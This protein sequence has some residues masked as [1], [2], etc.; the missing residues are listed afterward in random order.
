L[1]RERPTAARSSHRAL[2]V[3]SLVAA[4]VGCAHAMDRNQPRQKIVDLN[5]QALAAYQEED[6]GA[7]MAALTKAL[8]EAK[9]AG[10]GR[11][12]LTAR[13]YVHLGAVY[14]IGYRDLAMA[15]RSFALAKA[16]RP[17][18][19]MTPAI[20]TPELRMVFDEAP[21]GLTRDPP[22]QAAVTSE[23]DLPL[24]FPPRSPLVC[25]TPHVW[26]P[27]KA[28]S[29]RCVVDPGLNAESVRMH[30]RATH[31]ED[32]ETLSMQRS[33]KGWY[34][35]TV[36][37]RVVEPYNMQMY[38]EARDWSGK[39]VAMEGQPDRPLIIRIC[40]DEGS[41]DYPDLGDVDPD[42]IQVRVPEG[43]K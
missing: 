24:S 16:I 29:I 43:G 42:D 1:T 38:F 19:L 2:I 28:L 9:R 17:A 10:W 3:A 26:P 21:P 37:G 35:A 22:A 15:R 33:P 31:A 30:Y 41:C 18:V 36:S 8:E 7:A 5:R 11:S 40:E 34:V 6:F 14:L 25:R 32:F 20:A 39:D 4:S 23:P 12:R 13:T 27:G